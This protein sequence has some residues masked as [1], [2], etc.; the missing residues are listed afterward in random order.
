MVIYSLCCFDDKRNRLICL[1]VSIAIIL[2]ASVFAFTQPKSYYNTTVL[3]NG[4]SL[5]AEFDD[6]YT[7]RLED[8]S[9]G[10]VFIVY[11]KNIESFM[12]NAEFKKT[13][14]TRL[15]LTAPDGSQR[16]FDLHIDRS[17]YMIKDS[18]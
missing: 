13:G 7:V 17:S 3:V 1:I 6:K 14:D 4:G 8:E 12:V 2:G 16:I 10:N 18:K 15:I 11:E 9:Y 5:Q